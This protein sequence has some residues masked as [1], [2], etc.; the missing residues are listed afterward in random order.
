VPLLCLGGAFVPM[1]VE[2]KA[3][4]QDES[5]YVSA[6]S[7][8]YLSNNGL[9]HDL[10]DA[11]RWGG[12][13]PHCPRCAS[14]FTKRVNTNVF[15]QLYRCVDCS[16][17]FNSLSGTIFHGSK[18]PV[19]KYFHFFIMHNALGEQLTLR[20]ICFAL[21]CSFKTASIWLK[22]AD[23]IRSPTAF[24][25]VDKHL[26]SRFASQETRQTPAECEAFFS[27]CEMKAIVVNEA[28]LIDYVQHVARND[29]NGGDAFPT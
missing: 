29:V 18:M 5:L 24:G 12:G 8:P 9:A 23:E 21:D 17:M 3:D 1:E 7:L 15:R 2:N 13:Q 22:R 26:S 14:K 16:Y 28:L 6:R 19:Y 10:V 4:A 25:K 11:L 27:F 20:D